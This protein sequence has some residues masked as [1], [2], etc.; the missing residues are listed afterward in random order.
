VSGVDLRILPSPLGADDMGQL[1]ANGAILNS[2]QSNWTSVE[3]AS[4]ATVEDS[5]VGVHFE[6]IGY[7]LVTASI[8]TR[9]VFPS[10]DDGRLLKI[11]TELHYDMNWG[12]TA[13]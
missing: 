4:W 13:G 9:L 6:E 5:G 11:L 1:K 3:L 10:Q 2:F 12:G 7:Y 8:V